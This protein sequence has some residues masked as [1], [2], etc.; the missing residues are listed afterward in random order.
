MQVLIMDEQKKQKQQAVPQTMP[1]LPDGVGLNFEDVS[2]LLAEKSRVIVSPDDPILMMVPLLNAF[3]SEEH[4]LLERHKAALA[5]VM[6]M[7]TD[8]F[9]ESVQRITDELGKTLTASTVESLSAGLAAHS[10]DLQQH[11]SQIFWLSAIAA[12]SALVNVAVFV[13]IFLLRS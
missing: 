9:V 3:L 13:G 10:Q 6:A 1:V 4:A 2:R 8:G 7:K 12:T 11:R 5:Q